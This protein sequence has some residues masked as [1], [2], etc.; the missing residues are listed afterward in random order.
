MAFTNDQITALKNA[1]AEG[2][3]KVKY[4]DKEVEYRSLNDMIRTLKMMESEVNPQ[5]NSG[6]KYASFNN[7]LN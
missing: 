5:T 1:I 3:L 6:R 7:G 2:V 4:A